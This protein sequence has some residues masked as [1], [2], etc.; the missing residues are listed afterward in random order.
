MNNP[1]LIGITGGIGSGKSTICKIF[2]TLHVPVYEADSRAKWVMSEDPVL[3]A[4]IKAEFGEESYTEAGEL[5]RAYLASKVFNDGDQV[6][7]LNSLVHPRVGQDFFMWI[8]EHREQ[9]YLLNEAALMFES[10]RFQSLDKVITV[11]APTELRVQRVAQRDSQR[12]E[13]EIKAIIQKQMPEEEKI[14]KADYVIYNDGKQLVIPQVLKLHQTFLDL[15]QA[16]S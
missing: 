12:T 9:A 7:I 6:K 16:K 1:L 11:F 10:G 5:N 14:A 13:A 3:K 8:Q 15:Y 2:R 4:Q